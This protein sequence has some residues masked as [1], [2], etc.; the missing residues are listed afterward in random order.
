MT[1]RPILLRHPDRDRGPPVLAS[2]RG[3]PAIALLRASVQDLRAGHI[4]SG[5]S[6]LTMQAARLL[7]PRPRTVRSK[8]IE[9]ARALQLEWHF[10]KRE[11]LGIWLTLAPYGG[12]LGGV[13]GQA[14]WPGLA[15][16]P[17]AWT[18]RRRRC[19]WEFRAGPRLCR[20]DRHPDAARAVRDRILAAGRTGADAR[21]R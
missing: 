20:P 19:W 14:P 1:S 7:E 2:P 18:R 8:L 3:Q 17:A 13:Q 12:N 4:V 10:S 21:H 16:P 15:A 9:I 11:I 5:G 6:T